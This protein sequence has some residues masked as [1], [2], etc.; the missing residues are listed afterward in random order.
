MRDKLTQEEHFWKSHRR[1]ADINNHFMELVRTNNIT[2]NELEALIARRPEIW[3]RFAN[4]IDKLPLTIL[5]LDAVG[6]S[7][8]GSAKCPT[9]GDEP[10]QDCG[11]GEYDREGDFDCT[12]PDS[13]KLECPCIHT[14]CAN[15]A[16]RGGVGI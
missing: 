9:C 10:A 12:H 7:K 15:C 4:W 16:K 6:P 8:A 5:E 3:G 1:N 2:A 13:G 11:Y 14:Q